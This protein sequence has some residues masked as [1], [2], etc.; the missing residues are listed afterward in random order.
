MSDESKAHNQ[1]NVVVFI[2]PIVWNYFSNYKTHV[3]HP[4]LILTYTL[5][6]RHV[7]N[8]CRNGTEMNYSTSRD[9]QEPG[10]NCPV[11]V[12]LDLKVE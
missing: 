1:S 7:G 9:V 3:C 2:H 8:C 5:A 6:Y 11:V 10:L 4:N 12:L